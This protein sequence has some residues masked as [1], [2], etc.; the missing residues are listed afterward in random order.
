MKKLPS[1]DSDKNESKFFENRIVCEWLSSAQAAAYL[2]ISEN[3]LRIM[4]CRRQIKFHKLGRRLRFQINDIY[5]LFSR[6]G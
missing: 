1:T 3:A 5:S 6:K 4:V 2:C